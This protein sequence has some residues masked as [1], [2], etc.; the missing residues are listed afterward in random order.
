MGNNMPI[1]LP[2]QAPALQLLF[3][4]DFFPVQLCGLFGLVVAVLVVHPVLDRVGKI[5]L[6]NIVVRE[7][8]GIQIMLSLDCRALTVKMF[9]LQ[10]AWKISALPCADVLQSRVYRVYSRIGFWRGGKQDNRVSQGKPRFGQTQLH[11]AVHARFNNRYSLRIG[12]AD[13]LGGNDKQP[14]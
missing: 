8:V 4:F 13:I 10:M 7:I 9:V 2:A 6:L 3:T 14:P 12:K 1:S 5:L 11:R